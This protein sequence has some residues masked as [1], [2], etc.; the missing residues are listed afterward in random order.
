VLGHSARP[1]VQ[2]GA[3]R[4]VLRRILALDLE[5]KHRARPEAD[6]EVGTVLTHDAV[7]DVDDL[8]N[9]RWSFFTQAS[10]SS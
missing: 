9:P 8:S 7:E 10:T 3:L 1:L 4:L 2:G 6:Q 5:D